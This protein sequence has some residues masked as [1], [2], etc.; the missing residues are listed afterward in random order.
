M[1]HRS[2]LPCA[3]KH[4]QEALKCTQT[5]A[6]KANKTRDIQSDITG[7]HNILQQSHLMGTCSETKAQLPAYHHGFIHSPVLTANWPPALSAPHLHEHLHTTLG[8]VPATRQ[9]HLKHKHAP[10][11]QNYTYSA[12][13]EYLNTFGHLTHI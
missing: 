10:R 4:A 9:P 12:L 3:P 6:T 7:K 11:H 1:L 5:E 8:P 13:K 2:I